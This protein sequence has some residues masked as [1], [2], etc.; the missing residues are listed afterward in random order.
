[1]NPSKETKQL[2][3][4]IRH[5]MWLDQVTAESQSVAH[6]I[7]PHTWQWSPR[8]L[9]HSFM[10][11]NR[12]WNVCIITIDRW[13]VNK[14]NLRWKTTSEVFLCKINNEQFYRI[15]NTRAQVN[16]FRK[17]LIHK[18]FFWEIVDSKY[19]YTGEKNV[20]KCW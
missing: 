16:K 17:L 18:N 19:N 10:H 20:T 2:K 6:I 14:Q 4:G 9:A 15:D 8:L 13:I 7:I 12:T 3:D 1:M 11:R 5:E